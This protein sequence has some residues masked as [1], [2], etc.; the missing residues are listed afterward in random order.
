L[1]DAHGLQAPESN[2]HWKVEP[3]S[4]ELKAKLAPLDVVVAA[5]PELIDVCGAVV[6]VGGGKTG[7]VTGAGGPAGVLAR[8]RGSEPA[9]T[10]AP[11]PKPSPSVSNFLGFVLVVCSSTQL[12]SPSRSGSVCRERVVVEE[13]FVFAEDVLV[14]FAARFVTVTA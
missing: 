14:V 6:S 10:S 8:L 9:A 2:K 7:G 13:L 1:G 12:L 4:L 11:S 5:G 3:L